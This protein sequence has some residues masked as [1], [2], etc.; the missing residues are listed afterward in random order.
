MPLLLV[1]GWWCFALF[2]QRMSGVAQLQSTA[3][4]H[5]LPNFECNTSALFSKSGKSKAV[6]FVYEYGDPDN[7]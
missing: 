1:T 7:K 3:C 5:A 4:F 2:R 6:S